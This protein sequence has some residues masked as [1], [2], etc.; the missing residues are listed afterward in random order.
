MQVAISNQ[1]VHYLQAVMAGHQAAAG[2]LEATL[3]LRFTCLIGP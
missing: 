1:Y 3:G 2:T